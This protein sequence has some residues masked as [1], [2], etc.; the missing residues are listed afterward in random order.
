MLEYVNLAVA[1][2]KEE[3]KTRLHSLQQRLYELEHAVNEADIPVMIVFEG[4]AACG[5]GRL[6]QILAERMDPRGFRVVPITPPRTIETHYP[7][8]WRFWLQIPARGQMVAF[9]TSWYQHVIAD[10]INKLIDKDDLRRAYQEIAEFE[11]QLAADG[12]VILK[13]WL[14]ISQ[15]EQKKRLEKLLSDPFTAWQVGPADRLQQKK[16]EKF[17]EAVEDMLARTDSPNAPWSIVEAN[18]HYHARI[19]VFETIISALEAQL[20]LEP[21]LGPNAVPRNQTEEMKGAVN[22]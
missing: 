4:W 14:H 22:A 10:R 6:I 13:F 18:D 9:D 11:E 2:E 21:S 3:Y 8:L 5:K 16:Y 12:T 20:R 1:I 17:S 19:K 15:D 7:W